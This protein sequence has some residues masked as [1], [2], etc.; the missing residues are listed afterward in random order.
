MLLDLVFDLCGVLDPAVKDYIAARDKSRDVGKIHLLKHT[1]QSVHFK[2]PIAEVYPAKKCDVLL[3]LGFARRDYPSGWVNRRN[4]IVGLEPLY[5]KTIGVFGWNGNSILTTPRF[6][7]PLCV[8]TPSDQNFQD[9]KRAE[10]KAL[11][12]VTEMKSASAK[13]VDI[14]LAL[15]VAVFELHKD[16]LPAGTI[17]AIIQGHIKQLLPHY[18]SRLPSGN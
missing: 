1:S 12:L 4:A 9:Y 7:Q 14:E 18:E 17:S 5:E 11:E 6:A 8:M 13:K 15:I 3:H 10:K 16:T 2:A